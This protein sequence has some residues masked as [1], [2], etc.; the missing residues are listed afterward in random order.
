MLVG[1]ASK[2]A[3]LIVEFAK[4]GLEKGKSVQ[5]AAVEG[6]GLRFRP[7]VMTSF[8]FIFGLLPLLF[9]TGSGEASRKIL[10]LVVVFGMLGA[11]VLGL[12]VTPPL[13][14]IVERVVEARRRSRHEPEGTSPAPVGGTPTPTEAE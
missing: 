8:A 2:N 7:I 11:T 4:T 12:L 1:L 10:G 14:V 6:A 13:F 3:I 9:A 5:D